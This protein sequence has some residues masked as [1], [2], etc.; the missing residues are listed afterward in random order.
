M[1][2]DKSASPAETVLEDRVFE[3]GIGAKYF[4][5]QAWCARL[6]RRLVNGA[7]CALRMCL[8]HGRRPRHAKRVCIVRHFA[9][10]DIAVA[11]PAIYAVREA[12]PDAQLTLL[13]A[14]T[15]F[16]RRGAEGWRILEGARWLDEIVVLSSDQLGSR[17]GLW[18]IVREFRH[19]RFDV[20]IELPDNDLDVFR[21]IRNM[22]FARACGP[23]WAS[24]WQLASTPWAKQAQASFVS[25]PH[26]VDRL[27]TLV[28]SCG[29]A[30]GTAKFPIA[31]EN[32]HRLKIDELIERKG[33][34]DRKLVVIAPGAK[35]SSHRWP[36]ERFAEIGAILKDS[37]YSVPVLGG[38]DDRELCVRVA[39]KIG[40]PEWC[41]AGETSLL[42]SCELLRRCALVICNDSGVQHLA[43]L[44]AAPCLSLF[45]F[46]NLPRQWWPYGERSRV[47]QKWVPCYACFKEDCPNENLCLRLISVPEAQQVAFEMLREGGRP[48][49]DPEPT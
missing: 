23:R 49:H 30:A 45:A 25:F 42:E 34:A 36:E 29:L 38:N 4:R 10:G 8:W 24:G 17:M 21:L 18:S 27:L 48:V 1:G 32:R 31:I 5:F 26:E 16:G 46:T 37:N 15:G 43:A 39:G 47:I 28:G 11:I 9:I 7:L 41:L 20:W 2:G 19:C 22:L 3:K 14:P 44:V 6:E 13:T 12:Y 35:L 40:H 33:L